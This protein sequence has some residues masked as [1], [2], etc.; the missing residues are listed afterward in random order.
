MKKFDIKSCNTIIFLKILITN[1][2]DFNSN[3][4]SNV[5]KHIKY[6]PDLDERK[7]VVVLLT[8]T[9]HEADH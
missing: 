5:Q 4:E 1:N 8:W 9:T 2:C 6:L 3:H 7:N